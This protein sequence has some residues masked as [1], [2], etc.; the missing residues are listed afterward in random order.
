M[1][2]LR[3]PAGQ[4]RCGLCHR[5]CDPTPHGV[6]TVRRSSFLAR[7]EPILLLPNLLSL[8]TRRPPPPPPHFFCFCLDVDTCAGMMDR[9]GLT[10]CV[11]LSHALEVFILA[12]ACAAPILSGRSVDGG[13]DGT[14][15]SARAAR[16][17]IYTT[18][19]L[20]LFQVGGDAVEQVRRHIRTTAALP[21]GGPTVVPC[22]VSAIDPP[23]A[24]AW[25]SLCRTG[26]HTLCLELKVGLVG[27]S[28]WHLASAHTQF[29]P[30]S[31]LKC[32]N[33]PMHTRV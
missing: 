22:P 4:R 1:I 8:L 28:W 11:T 30:G 20:Q 32:L 13:S 23:K 17:F 21:S 14:G 7:V 16:Y 24:L 19:V 15:S 18:A 33:G 5:A 29:G 26:W 31:L 6:Q 25:L 3:L 2:Q 9:L 10:R 27:L 12:G